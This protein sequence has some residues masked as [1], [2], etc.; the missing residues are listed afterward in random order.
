VLLGVAVLLLVLAACAP[1]ATAQDERLA[2][3]ETELTS[4]RGAV[5]SMAEE[6]ASLAELEA[7]LDQLATKIGGMQTA[8]GEAEQHAEGSHKASPFE[9]A[10]AQYVLDTA[11]FHAMDEALNE[12]QQVE[13]AY[14]STVRRVQ[15]VLVNTSWPEEIEAD[16][17]AFMDLLTQ[18]EAAL[19][20][21]DGEGAASLATEVHDAQHDLSHGIDGWLGAAE[22][23]DEH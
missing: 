10:M 6:Q 12:T 16:A 22:G 13:P 18:L 8:S 5:N 15:K 11:G 20:A 19:E 3:L 4:L 21:D 9:I 1:G 23:E 17:Q 7:R 14:L 2:A